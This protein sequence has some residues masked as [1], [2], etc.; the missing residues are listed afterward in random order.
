MPVLSPVAPTTAYKIGEKTKDPL[1]M[2]SGGC[3]Y[4]SCQHCGTAGSVNAVWN[5]QQ[6]AANWNAAHWKTLLGTGAVSGGIC[7]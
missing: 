3:L 7:F 2:Y 1:E 6:G 4:G 5:R